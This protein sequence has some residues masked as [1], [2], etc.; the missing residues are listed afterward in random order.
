MPILVLLK[1][2][3][4]GVSTVDPRSFFADPY[5]DQALQNFKSLNFAKKIPYDVFA[6]IDPYQDRQ[7]GYLNLSVPNFNI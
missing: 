7:M 3:V 1:S 5:P 4:P 2:T 6:V